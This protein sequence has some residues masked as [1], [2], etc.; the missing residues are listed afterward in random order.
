MY[1]LVGEEV[2][3]WRGGQRVGRGYRVSCKEEGAG[4]LCRLPLMTGLAQEELKRENRTVINK[5]DQNT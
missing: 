1:G 2:S 3:L 4:L 5:A